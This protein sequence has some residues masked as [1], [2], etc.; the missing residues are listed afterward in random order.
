MFKNP[1]ISIIIP[2]LNRIEYISECIKS[3]K[4]QKYKNYEIIL[5][6]D[7]SKESFKKVESL[8]NVF[9]KNIINMG[10]SFSRN[11]GAFKSN[12]DILVFLD[13]DTKM[14]KESLLKLPEI[15][16]SDPF[17]GAIGGSGPPDNLS[18]DVKYI[19]GKSYNSFGQF[20]EIIIIQRNIDIQI[21]SLTVFMYQAHFLR[22]VGIYS[23]K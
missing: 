15:F 9:M 18:K 8:C 5:I 12:G 21:K 14:L 23:R 4:N 22:F 17:I 3:I 2:T 20:I 1:L 10:P 6:D 7:G 11:L 16:N 19:S 13:S